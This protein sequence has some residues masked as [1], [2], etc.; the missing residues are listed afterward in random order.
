MSNRSLF[1]RCGAAAVFALTSGLLATLV[2]KA[3]DQG[4]WSMKAH[5]PEPRDEL[6][7]TVL[8]GKLYAFG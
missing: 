8:G 1:L 5:L 2:A 7:M 3:A 4:T 6:A